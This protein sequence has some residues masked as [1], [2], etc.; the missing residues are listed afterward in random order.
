MK[1]QTKKQIPGRCS[2]QAMVEF[3]LGLVGIAVLVAM[4]SQINLISAGDPLHGVLGHTRMVV[5]LRNEMAKQLAENSNSSFEAGYLS[6]WQSGSDGYVNTADDM[7]V[8][9]NASSFL[10]TMDSALSIVDR[11]GLEEMLTRYG[12]GFS[13]NSLLLFSGGSSGQMGES[14]GIFRVENQT[15]ISNE[16]AVQRLVIGSEFLLLKHE[17][18][19][20][21]I[22]EID[23]ASG[24]VLN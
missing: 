11:P 22:N 14:F 12:Q 6:N 4:L 8:S 1:S 17:I 18:Y 21:Q 16:L 2:G 24:V 7:P 13:E 15:S 5:E 3:L 19:M 10:N 23:G 9:G 20:P